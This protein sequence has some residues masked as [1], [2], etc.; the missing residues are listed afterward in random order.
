MKA[1]YWIGLALLGLSCSPS[2]NDIPSNMCETPRYKDLFAT[3]DGF[4]V[5]FSLNQA[6]ACSD[7]LNK[8]V[9]VH[10]KSCCSATESLYTQIYKG[11]ARNYLKEHFVIAELYTD[12]KDVAHS[13]DWVMN[14][15][16]TIKGIG[17]INLLHIQVGIFELIGSDIALLID[18]QCERI[19]P[20]LITPNDRNELL[21]ILKEAKRN[22]DQDHR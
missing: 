15:S 9:F 11:E 17:K 13:S 8:P 14:E 5:Y 3:P 22:Y 10:F 19:V 18:G 2:L 1:A 4:D 7:Q 6:L 21:P 16:D 20:K 12:S